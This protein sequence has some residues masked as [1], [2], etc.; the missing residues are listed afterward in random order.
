MERLVQ[1]F[2]L[3]EKEEKRI[4][5]K[6]ENF[7]DY[8]EKENSKFL[9]TDNAKN[10]IERNFPFDF[11]GGFVGY[12]GYEVRSQ[13]VRNNKSNCSFFIGAE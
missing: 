1:I 6:N 2:D 4:I 12:L 7:F 9:L 10:I 13:N 11:I 8:F 3:N 5:L